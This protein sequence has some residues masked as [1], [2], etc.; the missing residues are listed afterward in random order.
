MSCPCSDV[1][2]QDLHKSVYNNTSAFTDPGFCSRNYSQL[3]FDPDLSALYFHLFRALHH[4][5]AGLFSHT[6]LTFLATD[7][8]P[9]L[10]SSPS[11]IVSVWILRPGN[12]WPPSSLH[13]VRL[14]VRGHV[15]SQSYLKSLG[16][17]RTAQVKR[18][19]RIGEAEA[20]C[21]A[22]IKV[23]H[24][25]FLFCFSPTF[26]LFSNLLTLFAQPNLWDCGSYYG[27]DVCMCVCVCVCVFIFVVACHSIAV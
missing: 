13:L 20:K 6:Y 16:K 14:P 27:F 18:D 15:M 7:S 10:L 5:S 12:I 17:P 24:I 25:L 11:P 3:F 8:L 2:V 1:A 22:G 9:A 21:E 4:E 23:K 19:G 26:F